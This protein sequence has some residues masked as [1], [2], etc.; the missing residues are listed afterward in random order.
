MIGTA[1]L[2]GVKYYGAARRHPVRIES[3]PPKL[4]PGFLTYLEQIAD[5]F[6]WKRMTKEKTLA[7][8]DRIA[9]AD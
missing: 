1:I 5:L 4:E 2:A 9:C 8:G 7:L 3:I 6:G